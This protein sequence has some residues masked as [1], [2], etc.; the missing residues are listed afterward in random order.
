[1][2]SDPAYRRAYY[3]EHRAEVLHQAAEWRRANPEKVRGYWQKNQ[4]M[5]LK[6]RH[7]QKVARGEYP[8]ALKYESGQSSMTFDPRDLAPLS[9]IPVDPGDGNRYEAKSLC[10]SWAGGW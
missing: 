4:F 5:R 8:L 7:R 1:M 10:G 3:R 6:V 2:P 9:V